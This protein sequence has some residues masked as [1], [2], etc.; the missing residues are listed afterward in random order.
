[1][2]NPE[3]IKIIKNQA[4][5]LDGQFSLCVEKITSVPVIEPKG[6]T[7]EQERARLISVINEQK[8][9]LIGVL[10]LVEQTLAKPGLSSKMELNH[11]NDLGQLFTNMKQVI[12]QIVEEQY[13]AKLDMYRQEI[14]KSIDIILDPIDMLIPSI[15]YELVH[16][17]KFYSRPSNSEISLLPE[18][19]SIVE[20]VEDREITIRQFLNGYIDDKET[21]RGYN[22]LRTL[23][24][25]FS[26]FQFYENSPEAY[27]PIN[28]KYQQICK[29][30]EPLLNERKSE[31]DLQKFLHRVRDKDF[32]IIKMNDIFKT[33]EF[34]KQLVKKTGK[35]YC[36]RKA[37]KSICAMLIDFEKF[38]KE[39]IVYNDDKIDNLETTLY[40]QSTNEAEKSRL[41]T[42]LQETRECIAD[43]QISFARLEMIFKKLESKNFNIIVKEKEED[44][45]TITI[46]PHHERKFGRDILERINLIIQEIDFW[47]PDDTK[48]NLFKNLS[49]VTKKIQND[50][51]ID[52]N[53]FLTLMKKYD[54]EIETNIRKSYP[55]KARELN[56]V[57][58]TFQKTFGGK[59]DRQRLERR[60]ENKEIWDF[61]HPLLKSVS[62]NLSILS[63]GSAS[64][65]KNVNKFSFLKSASEELNQL[66]YDLAMQT[67]IL[68]DGVEGKTITNMTD[69]LSTYNK[70]HDINALWGAFSYY[71]RKNA[72]PNV[73][74]NESVILQMSQN[75]NCK[76]YL[77]KMFSSS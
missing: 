69:I 51:P 22:E 49:K 65:K 43:R 60:L 34:L 11:L 73:A 29:T 52:K 25:Q 48:E 13:E 54:K 47:Y 56:N 4:E 23:N 45:I 8:P 38:Q 10:K 17:E 37:V 77:E 63:S 5:I 15:R 20:K 35:R 75:Q 41:K 19:R 31:P 18:I 16:L 36:Y 55:E 27:W 14:F 39:L 40:A 1:M 59:L 6:N 21:I 24:G 58:M 68:F 7:P 2:L 72:L 57:L 12:A 61:I 46:T 28:T 30:I 71:V 42:I 64:L 62:S 76:A 32:S 3:Q 50:E 66:L 70:F 67:F 26:S 9:K 33:H 44:D 53:E 74:V